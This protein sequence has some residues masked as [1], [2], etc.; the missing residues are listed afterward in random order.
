ML[1]I[2]VGIFAVA[3][4]FDRHP[5]RLGELSRSRRGAGRSAYPAAGRG[6]TRA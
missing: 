6:T 3:I 4:F 1:L 2:L 5:I